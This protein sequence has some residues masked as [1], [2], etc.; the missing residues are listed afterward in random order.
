MKW[1]QFFQPLI[2]MLVK[3]FFTFISGCIYRHLSFKEYFV[4]CLQLYFLLFR[5]LGFV[6]KKY[7]SI[8]LLHQPCIRQHL[9]L[10]FL[11]CVCK[12]TSLHCYHFT[13]IDFILAFPVFTIVFALCALCFD[14]HLS[15]CFV[16]CD[17]YQRKIPALHWSDIWVCT[18]VLLF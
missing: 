14:P 18:W 16:R 12:H 11:P 4:L 7:L 13:F 8:S 2:V 1:L 17:L 5:L 15:L 10:Y 3:Y 6:F 9:D